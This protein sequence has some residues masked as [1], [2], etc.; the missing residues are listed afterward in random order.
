MGIR[1]KIMA[2]IAPVAM[3]VKRNIKKRNIPLL[4]A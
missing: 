1:R 4:K 2:D 3:V